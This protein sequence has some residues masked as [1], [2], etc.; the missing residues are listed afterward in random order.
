MTQ[1]YIHIYSLL[2][3]SVDQY[4][5]HDCQVTENHKYVG[6]HCIETG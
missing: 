1:F 5:G 6:I 2:S 4:M 3:D